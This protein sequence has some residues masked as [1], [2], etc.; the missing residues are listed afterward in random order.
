M[1]VPRSVLNAIRGRSTEVEDW[2]RTEDFDGNIL[3]GAPSTRRKYFYSP[4]LIPAERLE[5]ILRLMTVPT[6]WNQ[7]LTLLH[8]HTQG[9]CL[10]NY[11]LRFSFRLWC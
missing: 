2:P 3:S 7:S 11:T 6:E 10:G 9:K 5:N 8:V 1:A 4:D